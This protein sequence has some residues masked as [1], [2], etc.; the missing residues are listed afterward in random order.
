MTILV[1]STQTFTPRLLVCSELRIRTGGR[2]RTCVGVDHAIH[3]LIDVLQGKLLFWTFIFPAE[4]G[5]VVLR[6]FCVR[7][8]FVGDSN[9]SV[10][11]RRLLKAAFELRCFDQERKRA[12]VITRVKG[13]GGDVVG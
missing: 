9:I 1:I 2:Y 7:T 8:R 3:D 12:G 10:R 6:K 5:L 11:V 4:L 13:V